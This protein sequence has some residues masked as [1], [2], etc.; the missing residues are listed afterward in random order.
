M[1]RRKKKVLLAAA[2]G[3]AG[4]PEEG[5]L[6]DMLGEMIKQLEV[7]FKKSAKEDLRKEK[8]TAKGKKAADK[9]EQKA[10]RE[11]AA[12]VEKAAKG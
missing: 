7:E 1:L 9:A 10:A 4:K 2:Q 6:K 11:E 3:D 8:E 12:S 5:V